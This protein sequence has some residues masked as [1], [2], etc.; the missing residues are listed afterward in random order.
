MKLLIIVLN[1]RTAGLTVDCLRSLRAEV[2]S[3]PGFRVTVID[4]GSGGDDLAV[5]RRAVA[6][7][8][9][10]AWAEVVASPENLGFTGGNNLV[11]RAALASA[12]RPEL[13]LLLNSDTVAEPGAVGALVSFLAAR[14]RVGIAGSA[15]LSAA[16]SLQ[17]SP[18]RF[19]GIAS[20]LDRGLQ[21]GLVS[22]LLRPWAVVMPPQ[23]QACAVDWVSGASMLLRRSMLEEVGLLDEGLFTYFDDV[24]LCLRARRAGW[25]TWYVPE[26]RVVH[27]EGASSGISQRELRRRPAYWFQA[28]R[29]FFLKSH[30][31]I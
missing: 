16:G 8:G 31:P 1:Y 9:W 11:I 29:R 12:D 30:G 13:F 22:R 2:V 28:R 7:N 26:S 18:F 15:L 4:N 27:L 23:P 19:Q 3:T 21:I 10:G 25:E 14:P 17:A 24:D 20:E 6:D 5:L